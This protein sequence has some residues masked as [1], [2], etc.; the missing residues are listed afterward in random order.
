MPPDAPIPTATGAPLA[1]GDPVILMRPDTSTADIAGFAVAAG[2]DRAGRARTHRD[3][4]RIAMIAE[5]LACCLLEKRDA[6]VQ[7]FPQ[8]TFGMARVG[9]EVGAELDGQ[10]EGRRH[11]EPERSHSSQVG[12]LGADAVG[13]VLPGQRAVDAHDMHDCSLGGKINHD[14]LAQQ[15]AEPGQ[16]VGGALDRAR[17]LEHG[18]RGRDIEAAGEHECGDGTFLIVSSMLGIHEPGHRRQRVFGVDATPIRHLG[19]GDP[20]AAASIAVVATV[21]RSASAASGAASSRGG[22][23]EAMKAACSSSST[24]SSTRSASWPITGR[25]PT[26][27][28]AWRAS[29]AMRSAFCSILPARAVSSWLL[30]ALPVRSAATWRVRRVAMS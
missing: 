20:L 11:R 17:K 16:A 27:A 9:N 3:Q 28:A 12:S 2:I 10:H 19:R 24:A 5:S 14:V 30:A 8:I 22:V 15:V 13:R 26:R 7:S 18:K 21:Q 29:T 4:Q 6:R 23:S 25:A 1:G